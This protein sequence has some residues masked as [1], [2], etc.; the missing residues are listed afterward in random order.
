MDELPLELQPGTHVLQEPISSCW[1]F[2]LDDLYQIAR[3][4]LSS[5]PPRTTESSDLPATNL[6]VYLTYDGLQKL[7]IDLQ[8]VSKALGLEGNSKPVAT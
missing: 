5:E 4:R 7:L 8:R 6:D 3:I 1:I 2:S